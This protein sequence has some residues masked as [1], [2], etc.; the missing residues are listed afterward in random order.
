[1]ARDIFDII[2]DEAGVSPSGDDAEA[3]GEPKR[4]G[5]PSGA[6]FDLEGMEDDF[7]EAA[8]PEIT[9]RR[10]PFKPFREASQ[11]SAGGNSK[12]QGRS[13]DP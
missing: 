12:G 3:Q 5:T 1:M 8:P 9:D 2:D 6:E 4:R 10:D 13:I 11:R 7:P